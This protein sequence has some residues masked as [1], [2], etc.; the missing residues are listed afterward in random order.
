[1]HVFQWFLI[2]LGVF[3][4]VYVPTLLQ[5]IAGFARRCVFVCVK[6]LSICVRAYIHVYVYIYIYIYII[7]IYIYIHICNIYLYTY[8]Y[9]SISR[10]N[11]R[12]KSSWIVVD[13]H[14]K[15]Q[16][17]YTD[18]Y[19]MYICNSMYNTFPYARRISLAHC[20]LLNKNNIRIFLNW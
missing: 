13:I 4:Y 20:R 19:T 11:H 16:C 18:V 17:M 12:R 10:V 5:M 14:I 6:H 1:M 3:N 2:N 9:G 7:F 15:L 8:I